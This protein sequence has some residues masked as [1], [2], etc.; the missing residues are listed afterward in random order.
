MGHPRNPLNWCKCGKHIRNST[1]GLCKK[2]W[3]STQIS[4]TGNRLLSS[5]TSTAARHR[6]QKVRNHAKK[7]A[8]A[9]HWTRACRIC[10]YDKH[11]ELCH[12]KP[13]AAFQQTATFFEINKVDNLVFLCPNHHWELDAGL[14]AGI[15]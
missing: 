11:V 5:A 2:C 10:G 7:L 14:L 15:A 3:C 1:S 4:K 13:I 12:I 9:W 6:H 8:K